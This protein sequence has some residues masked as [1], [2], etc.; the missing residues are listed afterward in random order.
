MCLNVLSITQL[1]VQSVDSVI[2]GF[3][4]TLYFNCCSEDWYVGAVV[5]CHTFDCVNLA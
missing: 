5:S 1:E 4:S 3:S 2:A